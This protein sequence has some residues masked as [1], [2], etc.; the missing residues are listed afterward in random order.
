VCDGEDDDCNGVVDDG[1]PSGVS[2]V[3]AQ[4]MEE[5]G[6]STGGSKFADDCADGAVLAGIQVGMAGYLRQVK[7]VCRKL[8][9]ERSAGAPSGYI[10]KLVADAELAPHPPTTDSPI[11]QTM[12]N[13]NETLVGLR[14]SQQYTAMPDGSMLAVIPQVTLFCAKLTVAKEGDAYSMNW[15][16]KRAMAPVTGSDANDTAWFAETAIPAGSVA[17]R[18]AGASGAWIDRLALGVSNVVIARAQ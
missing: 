4:D 17:T 1:C 14:I 9:L 12:C 16:G 10:V 18:L 11:S 8:Q 3:F 2:T 5:L 7:G 15:E 13:E 6:D